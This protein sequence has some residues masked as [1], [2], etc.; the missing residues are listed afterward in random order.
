M[1]SR[2]SSLSSRTF[3]FASAAVMATLLVGMAGCATIISGSRQDVTVNSNPQAAEIHIY[4]GFVAGPGAPEVYAGRTPSSTALPR[5]KSY[6]IAITAAGYQEVRVRIDKEFNLW[7][8]GNLI[9]GGLVGGAV[10]YFT[11]AFW[12]LEPNDVLVT[13][14]PGGSPGAPGTA[15][16]PGGSPAPASSPASQRDE[17]GADLYAI[18]VAKDSEG[19]LRSVSVPMIR[20]TASVAAK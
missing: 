20:D 16:V 9:C 6:T 3:R 11:G 13:L 5:D 12:K 14:A 17:G 15:P 1:E 10:D 4:Q 2:S 19:Q 8:L 7:V 18:F